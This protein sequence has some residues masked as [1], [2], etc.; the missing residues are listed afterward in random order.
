MNTPF[1]SLG[2]YMTGITE[3]Q[4]KNSPDAGRNVR[5]D[6]SFDRANETTLN[7]YYGSQYYWTE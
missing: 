3:E 2:G 1:R 4:L 5:N 6:S 7:D